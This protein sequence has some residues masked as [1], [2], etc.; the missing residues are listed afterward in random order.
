MNS[1]IWITP[2]VVIDDFNVIRGAIT[3]CKAQTKLVVHAYAVLTSP[4]ALESLKPV[5]RRNSKV[6]KD[7]SRLKLTKFARSDAFEGNIATYPLP[8]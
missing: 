7:R 5:A 8:S 6:F 3:P 2:L 1:A 4:V